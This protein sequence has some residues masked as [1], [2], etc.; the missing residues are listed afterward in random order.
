MRINILTPIP[1]WHPGTE[2]LIQGLREKGIELVSLDIWGFR[3]YDSNGKVFNLTPFFLKGIFVRIYR[4]LFR[5]LIIK[6]YIKRDDIVDIQWCGHYY[7]KYI[8]YIKQREVKIIAT[9]FGSDLYR[10]SENEKK[11]QKKIFEVA[12]II[13]MGINMQEEFELFFKGFEHKYEFNQYGSKRLDLIEDLKTKNNKNIIRQKYGINKEKIV[14]TIGYNAKIEQQH[15]IFLK[16]IEQLD[17]NMKNKLHL[18]FPLT[19]GKKDSSIYYN[20][21]KSKIKNIGIDYICLE[22]RLS[23]EGI[24]ETKI[25]SDITVNLQTTDALASSIKEAIVAD[26]ILLVGDWLPY[27]IYED[28][29]I[30]FERS[31]LKNFKEKFINIVENIESY[32]K[33]CIN[34][35]P[36]IIKFASWKHIIPLLI[37]IYKKIKNERN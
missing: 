8:D 14:V 28:L 11:I 22:E 35:S 17:I 6:K 10:S 1:F 13:V 33:R 5:K 32:K 9:L 30:F 31:N 23:D 24:S 12:D 19:Y 15:L 25:I 7:S 29:G 26:D 36:K 37:N 16:E 3:Y 27:G 2:E 21:L 18:L 20:Q 4:K 34:N